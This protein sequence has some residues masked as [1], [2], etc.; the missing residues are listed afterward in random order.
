MQYM[1]LCAEGPDDF[2]RRN[3][4]S[5]GEYWAS[6][7]AYSQALVQAGVF[8]SGAGLLGPEASTTVRVRGDNREVQD[9]P[10]SDAKEQLGGFFIIEA[11][12]LDSALAWAARSPSAA[13]ASA[14][15]R[16][17]MPMGSG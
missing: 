4:P 10:Y 7:S 11:P 16:P 3:G 12:D 6:W 2:A 15:V 8:V 13:Y 17:V 1:I 14:E 9:G 5:A